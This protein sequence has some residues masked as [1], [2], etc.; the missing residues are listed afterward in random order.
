MM[1]S[2]IVFN[3]KSNWYENET[4]NKIGIDGIWVYFNIRKFKLQYASDVC[5]FSLDLLYKEI[6]Q[7][8]KA[9][10][11]KYSKTN[12]REIIFKLKKHKIVTFDKKYNPQTNS[13]LCYMQLLDLPQLDEKYKPLS[14]EDYFITVDTDTINYIFQ[15]GLNENH[16]ITYYCLKKYINVQGKAD[17]QITLSYLKMGEWLGIDKDTANKYAVELEQ[18]KIIANQYT[19][20]Q[21]GHKGNSFILTNNKNLGQDEE[22]TRIAEKNNIKR[23]KKKLQN[24]KI[25]VTVS[26]ID[27][28][29]HLYKYLTENEKKVLEE[30]YDINIVYAIE[31]LYFNLLNSLEERENSSNK[32]MEDIQKTNKETGSID[33]SVD[34]LEIIN[35]TYSEEELEALDNQEDECLGEE[36]DMVNFNNYM[37]AI[38]N[39][40]SIETRPKF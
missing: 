25:K 40:R 23:I 7:Y 14:S 9:N 10:N 36:F 15:N 27:E 33:E 28:K 32:F 35:Y 34:D 19:K 5:V 30:K 24:N 38:E 6:Q 20:L 29:K 2:K 4:I 11:R 22:I 3:F 1:N 18:N 8:Y 39:I 37:Q 13:D 12:L 26:A 16:I 17:G 21:N 31:Y